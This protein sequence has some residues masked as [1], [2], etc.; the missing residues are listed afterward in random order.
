MK[1][2]FHPLLP[3]SLLQEEDKH[4]VLKVIPMWCQKGHISKFSENTLIQK[5]ADLEACLCVL[6]PV[7]LAASP[8]SWR[9]ILLRPCANTPVVFIVI[10]S[11]RTVTPFQVGNIPGHYI[12]PTGQWGGF[13]F[14][15]QTHVC[16]SWYLSRSLSPLPPPSLHSAFISLLC[17]VLLHQ[18][19][20]DL[21]AHLSAIIKQSLMK[22]RKVTSSCTRVY[23]RGTERLIL[24]RARLSTRVT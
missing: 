14:I 3:C 2:V 4:K 18:G 24:A 9:R 10:L 22:S 11:L 21:W 15:R 20:Y 17:I 12:F 6:M 5:T 13:D 16:E 7:K 1:K 19:T 23:A 8:K